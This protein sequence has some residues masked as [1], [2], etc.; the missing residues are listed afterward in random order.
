MSKI[1]YQDKFLDGDRE[2]TVMIRNEDDCQRSHGRCFVSNWSD[3]LR[4]HEV[5]NPFAEALGLPNIGSRRGVSP[6]MDKAWDAFNSIIT[7]SK[8]ADLKLV[9]S[10]VAEQV[11]ALKDVELKF[12]RKA[13]CGCGCSPGFIMKG[14]PGNYNMWV[15][16]KRGELV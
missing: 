10:K 12:D 16:L 8:T 2:V 4:A 3:D 11:P 9:L 5:L 6:P 1:I 15:T 7:D 14:A 13:G